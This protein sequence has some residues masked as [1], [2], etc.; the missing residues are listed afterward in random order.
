MRFSR[1][2]RSVRDDES[3]G[4]H[5]AGVGVTERDVE[6]ARDEGE[7]RFVHAHCHVGVGASR[8]H[9]RSTRSTFCLRQRRVSGRRGVVV[10][11]RFCLLYHS[12]IKTMMFL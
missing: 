1:E 5:A 3:V 12:A 4:E 6:R 9:R 10:L 2:L 8:A 7:R 11:D